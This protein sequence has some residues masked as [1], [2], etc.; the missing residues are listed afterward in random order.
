MP[1]DS[2]NTDAHDIFDA[3]IRQ[4]G[5]AST[6]PGVYLMKNAQ[7]N[8]LYVGKARNLK[9]RLKSYFNKGKPADPKTVV[10][11]GQVARFET[12]V[13]H[14][15]KEALILE[16]NLIKRHRPRYNVVLKDDKRYP[17]LRLNIRHTYPNLNIV[18]KARNDGALYFG[19]YASSTAVRQTLKFIHKT[20]RLRKC[21]SKTYMNRSRPCLNF[22][23]GLCL[24]PCCLDVDTERYHGIVKE[25][26][27][28]L[29]GRTPDLIRDIR[30]QMRQAAE[31][32]EYEVAAVLR[33]KIVALEKTLEKQV[34]VSNDF[35]DRDAVGIA[36]DQKMLVMTVLK[37]RSGFLMG[38]RHFCFNDTIGTV[39][40][41]LGLFLRQYYESAHTV[42][43][44]ILLSETPSDLQLMTMDLS[45]KRDAKVALTIP[46]RGEKH[47]LVRMA[48]QNAE[49]ALK[50]YLKSEEANKGLIE[51]LRDK[52]KLGQ[53]PRRIECFD[54]SN[55]QG[56]QPVSGMVVFQNAQ[57]LPSAYRRYN[58]SPL[59]Q[60]D[61]YAHM[62]EVIRR[63]FGK[64]EDSKPF[65]DLLLVDGG[66][67]QLNITLSVLRELSLEN[68]FDVAGIA[69]KDAARGE[70]QD[71]IYLAGRS[72]AINFHRDADLLL[73]LQRIRDEAHRWAIG[74]QRRRRR[75]HALTSE[76]DHIAGIGPKRRAALLKHFGDV[77][78]IRSSSP[79]ELTV[80]SGISEN[81]ADTILK[82]LNHETNPG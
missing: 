75:Q 81:L 59:G 61:D 66:K 15:E 49:L 16:S 46:R 38:R 7:G 41:Q 5:R 20:F 29:K 57:P 56:S 3:L 70:R 31:K 10:L 63:R 72:N 68:C 78:S 48:V 52:L 53:L 21:R 25:V 4:A 22:Q 79:N 11:L 19:P 47:R 39:S 67:G 80:V 58:V 36:E 1:S 13:T 71:K 17:S 77:E 34:S 60:P 24:G 23:M 33:D 65:P 55:L 40:E 14:T 54:N 18:R 64:G 42:P 74:F 50:E 30:R 28:F 6:E 35:Q 62:M 32:Q 9:N 69:K 27:A 82:I 12:M 45:E 26:I 73:F 37:V 76:L 8:I 51:R 43:A 44:E 2:K